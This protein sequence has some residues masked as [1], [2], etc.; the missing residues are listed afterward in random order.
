[1]QFTISAFKNYHCKVCGSD[2]RNEPHKNGCEYEALR[3]ELFHRTSEPC[4]N[5]CNICKHGNCSEL[6]EKC[7]QSAQQKMQRTNCK[8]CGQPLVGGICANKSCA[9]FVPL[10]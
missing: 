3:Q 7:K 10:I 6:C 5:C 1:M 2:I 9:K 8:A 4:P